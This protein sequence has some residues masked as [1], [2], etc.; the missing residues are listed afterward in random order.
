[1]VYLNNNDN[2]YYT[3]EEFTNLAQGYDGDFGNPNNDIGYFIDGQLTTLDSGGYGIWNNVVYTSGQPNPTYTGQIYDVIINTNVYFINGQLTTLNDRGN[4]D[5]NGSHYVYGSVFTDGRDDNTGVWYVNGQATNLNNYGDGIIDGIIYQSGQAYPNYTG[6]FEGVYYINGQTTTLDSAGQGYWN[7]IYYYSISNTAYETTLDSNGNGEWT[8]PPDNIQRHFIGGYTAYG[9]DPNN[10]NWYRDGLLAQGK[11]NDDGMWYFNGQQSTLDYNGSGFWDGKAY[12]NGQ[13]QPTGWNDYFYYID[14]VETTLDSGGNGTYNGQTYV[15]G[16]VQ[17]GG[18]GS[19]D[20]TNGL[21]AFYKLSDTSDSSGNNRTLTNN[22]NVSFGSGKI[23]NAAVFDGSGILQ[24]PNCNFPAQNDDRSIFGWLKTSENKG[25]RKFLFSYG[26]NNFE[27]LYCMAVNESGCLAFYLYSG[28]GELN[29]DDPNHLVDDDSWHHFGVIQ[30]SSQRKVYLDGINIWSYEGAVNT[31]PNSTF[32]IGAW[33]SAEQFIGQIDAVGIWNRALS[34]AEIAELYNNGTGLELEVQAPTIDLESGLQAFYKLSDT[35]D[36]S[37]NNRNLTNNGNVSFASGKIGNAA[38]FD[39]SNRL[40]MNSLNNISSY[41]L[42]ISTWIK[43]TNDGSGE[44]VLA[45]TDR[46]YGSP[47]LFLDTGNTIASFVNGNSGWQINGSTYIPDTWTHI[48]GVFEDAN[49]K[50]FIN[51]V[52][53]GTNTEQQPQDITLN[54]FSIGSYFDYGN[55]VGQIDAVGIWNRALS[56]AEIAEL[57]NNGTGLELEV[58]APTIDLES[59][60]QAFYKLSDTSDSSGNNRNL[61]NNG[62]VSFASGKIGNAAIFDGSDK[63]LKNESISLANSSEMTFSFWIKTS[64]FSQPGC[65]LIGIWG[66]S[67]SSDTQFEAYYDSSYVT[68]LVQTPDGEGDRGMLSAPTSMSI[69]DG[70]WHHYVLIFKDGNKVYGIYDGVKTSVNTYSPTTISNNSAYFGIGRTSQ[71]YWGGANHFDGQIDAAGVWNRALS[72][73]E[74]A[75]L[76]NNGT[77]LE[78]PAG[79]A[80]KNGWIDGIYYINDVATSLDQNGNGTWVG[81]LYENGSLF[82]G[83]K[84]EL[85]FVDGVAQPV[86]IVTV[87]GNDVPVAFGL[88][89]QSQPI[90]KLV[91]ASITNAGET[92]VEQIVPTVIPAGIP[93]Q[94]T[95]AQTVLAYS[96]DTTATFEGTINVDF[97][98]PSNISQTVFNRVKAFHVK[99]NGTAEELTRVTSDFST[100]KITVAISSFSSFLFMDEPPANNSVKVVGKSKFVGKV[101]FA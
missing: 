88:N 16:V 4:G 23:G 72:D 35:S 101:K 80:I 99:N 81:K 57:Y 28:A 54:N 60:L 55:A 66:N 100:K 85:T 48:V 33:N 58:Q 12:Y 2:L 38:V 87:T 41:P 24:L 70:N 67:N 61:T 79:P 30:S 71:T 20:L 6:S 25:I 8:T 59:G 56:D 39:G 84:Y 94:Y 49:R 21:Q 11:S 9:L 76:Y 17:G 78:L 22:G 19:I 77:G 32:E 97:I 91:F 29:T 83:T 98:L 93:A 3:E 36:S 43:L 86:Q 75:A 47:G 65:N 92:T 64:N 95:V 7:G 5:W 15:N 73:A 1:M 26:T 34:D 13:E 68:G 42:T 44:T 14:N 74:V 53:A 51:G 63:V 89:E 96:I 50:L 10:N 46:A 18:G 62:N 31:D 40:E 45:A 37:G 90:V 82:S 52:L 69:A 27:V